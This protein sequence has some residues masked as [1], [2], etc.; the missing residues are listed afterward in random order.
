MTE[1]KHASKNLQILQGLVYL[2]LVCHFSKFQAIKP[3]LPFSIAAHINTLTK[4]YL[5]L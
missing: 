2:C 1:Q 5:D 4:K 3:F